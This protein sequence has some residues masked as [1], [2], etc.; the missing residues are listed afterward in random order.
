MTSNKGFSLVEILLSVLV[1]AIS[2]VGAL[3]VY[4]YLEVE[5]DNALSF[6][7][8][9][10][11]AETQIAI[12]QTLNTIGSGC[13][14]KTVENIQ[15]CVLILSE[16]SLYSLSVIPTKELK[17]TPVGGAPLTYAKIMDVKVSWNDR[18]GG[19]QSLLLPVSVSKHTNLLD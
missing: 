16:D 19:S 1:L 8:A 12:L 3:K 14:G 6:I 10:Q 5:K 11:I 15:S 13:E 7:E 18:N 9:K 4:S 2:G 17:Y